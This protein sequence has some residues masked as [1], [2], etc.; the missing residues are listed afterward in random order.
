MCSPSTH[1]LQSLRADFR[2][3]DLRQEHLLAR[4]EKAQ[5]ES[6]DLAIAAQSTSR[7]LETTRHAAALLSQ[8]QEEAARLAQ[9]NE[10]L[11]QQVAALQQELGASEVVFRNKSDELSLALDKLARYRQYYAASPGAGPGRGGDGDVGG[12]TPRGLEHELSLSELASSGDARG[13]G[14]RGERG[15]GHPRGDGGG[16]ERMQGEGGERIQE[17]MSSRRKMVARVSLGAPWAPSPDKARHGGMGVVGEED[18]DVALLTGMS[19]SGV[20]ASPRSA[21]LVQSLRK[22][23]AER[24][25]ALHS[26]QELVETMHRQ[27]EETKTVLRQTQLHASALGAQLEDKLKMLHEA[28]MRE[29]ALEKE[30]GD[31]QQRVVHTSPLEDRVCTCARTHTLTLAR[32]H[33]RKFLVVCQSAPAN[34]VSA[35]HTDTQT[36]NRPAHKRTCRSV[37]ELR[38][39]TMT[40]MLGAQY[41]TQGRTAK[42]RIVR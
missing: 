20:L 6:A 21:R 24:E 23:L 22:Q 1:S 27:E 5:R 42:R 12:L 7:E 3:C 2:E 30:L 11:E 32:S 16:G 41:V 26:S 17:A 10:A 40:Q 34:I 15:G 37:H 8:T 36:I 4:L 19:G 28:A 18:G 25:L 31:A 35:A 39:L 13:S 29:E 9:A 33:T 14:G 38:A